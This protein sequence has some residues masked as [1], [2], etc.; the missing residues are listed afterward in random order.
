MNP[1]PTQPLS[2]PPEPKP[3][4]FQSAGFWGKRL[5]RDDL[6]FS[7]IW[8][9]Y[10]AGGNVTMLTS[11]WKSG[12]TTMVSL[13]LSRLKE[14]GQLAG[15]KVTPAKAVILS[16]EAPQLWKPRHQLLDLGHIY[17]FC[18]PFLGKP[19]LEQWRAFIDHIAELRDA[20][21]LDLFIIDTLAT[22]LPGNNE[23]N[24]AVVMNALLPLQRLTQLGMALLFLHH[25]CKGTPLPGQAA[26]G[27]G[28]L[29]GFVDV[30]IEKN[31]CAG[32]DLDRCRKLLAF[33]RHAQTPAQR[34]I[35]L[36]A[37]GTDYLTRGDFLEDEFTQHWTCLRMVL[38]DAPN[39]RTRKQLLADWPADFAAP[40]DMTLS[41]WL[42]RAVALGLARQEGTG[43]KNDPFRY[44]LPEQ[45]AKWKE[46]PMYDIHQMI[47]EANK[48]VLKDLG[49][50][51]RSPEDLA[52]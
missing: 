6:D 41:R 52:S 13:L 25:P 37:D 35:E 20:H 30:I 15:L 49:G 43:R 39:K 51:I 4:A 21:G 26:R 8:D 50:S 29:G 19:S 27:S 33:S 12:K 11:Q 10:I 40:A 2:Q 34:V 3:N 38:E 45:E 18:R 16:E 44:W 46:D 31:F 48:S 1:E 5:E 7:W 28:A 24:A 36:S 22:F 47:L 14:G 17:F 42:N 23:A 9:G 32:A